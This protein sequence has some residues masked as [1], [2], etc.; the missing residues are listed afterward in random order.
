MQRCRQRSQQKCWKIKMHFICF[1]LLPAAWEHEECIFA[2][3]RNSRKRL[4]AR[5]R[6]KCFK[7][8]RNGNIE[9][10]RKRC[11][12]NRTVH[13]QLC[14]HF[15]VSLH[16]RTHTH[17]VRKVHRPEMGYEC[18]FLHNWTVSGFESRMV[19][20]NTCS[21]FAFEIFRFSLLLSA[22]LRVCACEWVR[23]MHFHRSC[24]LQHNSI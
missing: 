16:T 3:R 14:S 18:P 17:T 4:V 8:N 22:R 12:N 20:V 23:R 9:V 1:R 19:R 5:E 10:W 11:V 7:W 13:C 6:K 21:S 2:A 24:R 15:F